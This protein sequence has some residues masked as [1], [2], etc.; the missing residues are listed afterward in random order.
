MQNVK[1]KT[2]NIAQEQ[3]HEQISNTDLFRFLLHW[4]GAPFC[5]AMLMHVV[6]YYMLM[7]VLLPSNIRLSAAPQVAAQ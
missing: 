6:N 2:E 5:L 3:E 1:Q 7:H 4:V